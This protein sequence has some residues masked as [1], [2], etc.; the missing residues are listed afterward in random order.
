[1]PCPEAY[2]KPSRIFKMGLFCTN[3]GQLLFS[4]QISIVDIRVCSSCKRNCGPTTHR[5]VLKI[6]S[7]WCDVSFS[8]FMKMCLLLC[9][10]AVSWKTFVQPFKLYISNLPRHMESPKLIHFNLIEEITLKVIKL[11][12]WALM[13]SLT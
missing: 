5:A 9:T 2:L 1:M 12:Y 8:L 10:G 7:I 4:Q 3:C 11:Y 6:P 13:T